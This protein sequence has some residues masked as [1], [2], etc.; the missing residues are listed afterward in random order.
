[1]LFLQLF[2]TF[3]KIGLFTFGG[4]YAMIA[5]IQNEVTVNHA[6]LTPQE[7]TDILAVSQMTPGPVGINTAT[8]T[9]YTAVLNA[10]Y[11]TWLAVLGA[12]MASAAVILLP[13]VLMV[14]AV[15]FLRKMQGNKDIENVFR[16][17]RMTIVGLIAAAAL[18]LLT[19]DS[20]G[21]PA[22]S[23]Q[24]ILSIAIFV[25][26]FALSFKRVSPILLILAAGVL[27]IIIYSMIPMLSL[28]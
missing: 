1:M 7:F 13:V 12:L 27:G 20:F 23:L 18:Q 9:G 26:V 17:L 5:L 3:L 15:V 8:Y 24:F 10:G 19:V 16:V 11:D 22:F 2:W 14:I 21:H 28:R 25:A 6:W 4:G